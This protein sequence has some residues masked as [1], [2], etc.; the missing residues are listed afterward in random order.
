MKICE[1][2]EDSHIRTGKNMAQKTWTHTIHP[3]TPAF[4]ARPNGG[5]HSTSLIF[6]TGAMGYRELIGR[7][8]RHQLNRAGNQTVDKTMPS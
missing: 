7:C 3:P 5:Y 2:E 8:R 6:A 4:F 1:K